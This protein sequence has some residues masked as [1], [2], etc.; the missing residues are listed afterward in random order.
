[1]KKKNEKRTNRDE[2]DDRWSEKRSNC[3]TCAREVDGEITTTA[4]ATTT[5][6]NNNNNN[7]NEKRFVSMD[8]RKKKKD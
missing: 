3:V 5:Y 7:K 8:G 6:N 2:W 4:S 1:M